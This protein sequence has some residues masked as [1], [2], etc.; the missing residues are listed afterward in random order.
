MHAG[1]KIENVQMTETTSELHD[2]NGTAS[3]TNLTQGTH[4]IT[5]YW[6]VPIYQGILNSAYCSGTTQFD[7]DPRLTPT[8][9]HVIQPSNS[10]AQPI[11]GA[12]IDLVLPLVVASSMI[13][14]GVAG[15][16]LAYFRRRK[17]K[18]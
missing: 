15:S 9:L 4:S 12:D 10:T 14:L 5:V 1:N 11:S 16:L 7:V 18:L 17:G 6:G 13:V 2:F 3:L 8:P